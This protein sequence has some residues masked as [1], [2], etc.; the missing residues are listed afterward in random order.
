MLTTLRTKSFSVPPSMYSVN[1]FSF[2][3]LYSTPMNLSTLGW[4]RLR[5]TF[6]WGWG[7]PRKTGAYFPLC[8]P[9][10]FPAGVSLTSVTCT[11]YFLSYVMVKNTSTW[12]GRAPQ[13]LPSGSCLSRK[14]TGGCWSGTVQECTKGLEDSTWTTAV[15]SQINGA[16]CERWEKL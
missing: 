14:C 10:P 9:H 6:T 15:P 8:L 4:S 13:A 11:S 16:P 5:I 3:S 7:R 1:R 12:V 2:L